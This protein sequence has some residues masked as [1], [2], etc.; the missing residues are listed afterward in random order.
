[1]VDYD[2]DFGRLLTALGT[3]YEQAILTL[4]TLPYWLAFDADDSKNGMLPGTK[5]TPRLTGSK[6]NAPLRLSQRGIALSAGET[7]SVRYCPQCLGCDLESNGEPFWHRAHQLPNVFMCHRH[8]CSLGSACPECGLEVCPTG[9][10]LISLPPLRCHCGF[11]L[12]RG[13]DQS[14]VSTT[15]SS[16]IRV[17]VEALGSGLPQWDN[18]KVRRYLRTALSAQNGTF[19]GSYKS[20]LSS[21]FGVTGRLKGR[22]FGSIPGLNGNYANLRLQGEYSKAAAPECCALLAALDVDFDTATRSFVETN[23][24]IGPAKRIKPASRESLTVKAVRRE[25]RNKAATNPNYYPCSD[26]IP[27]WYLRIYDTEWLWEQFPFLTQKPFQSV[28]ED[29]TSITEILRSSSLQPSERHR[30]MSK[31]IPGLRARLRDQEW[32]REQLDA[33]ARERISNE[34][35]HSERLRDIRA[36]SIEE[37][38]KKLARDEG[39]RPRRIVP[40]MLTG[41]TCL[42]HIQIAFIIRSTP[43]LKKAIATVNAER[44]RR[45]LLWAARQLHTEGHPLVPT[46]ICMR[47]DV[48]GTKK[49]ILLSKAIIA[50]FER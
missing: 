37:A 29:R 5:Q 3:S 49:A 7:L 33:A 21:A 32:L 15:Y 43:H 20:A 16:L 6:R 11:D 22:L 45:I 38:V 28:S 25:I 26:L 35:D 13:P 9:K 17:S 19:S 39:R 23:M 40:A 42:S 50:E 48:R 41:I 14:A 46:S 30:K 10:M 1:M 12:R 47:A 31:S 4:T 8:S 44:Y 36:V 24:D 34:Q 27:Y 18:S 2:E